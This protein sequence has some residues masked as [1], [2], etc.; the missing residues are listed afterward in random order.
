VVGWGKVETASIERAM[1]EEGG[2]SQWS[3]HEPL[4]R[5][6]GIEVEG[7]KV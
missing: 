6:V 5:K 3:R 4:R 7:S 2:G 1:S